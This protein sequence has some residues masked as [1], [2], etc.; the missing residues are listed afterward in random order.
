MNRV[1]TSPPRIPV[2]RRHTLPLLPSLLTVAAGPAAPPPPDS[3]HAF[4]RYDI[5]ARGSER[6][7]RFRD[8]SK[9][10]DDAGFVRDA[11]EVAAGDEPDNPKHTRMSGTLP[12]K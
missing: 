2:M 11:E 12:S 3:Y 4:I 1:P 7:V 9:A 5:L 6:I 10:L 8:Y